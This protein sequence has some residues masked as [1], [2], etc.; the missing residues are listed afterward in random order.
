MTPAEH[1]RDEHLIAS[2]AVA[3]TQGLLV[4]DPKCSLFLQEGE[5][6]TYTL[7]CGEVI[8]GEPAL[9]EETFDD[10]RSA[11]GFF[12]D[13]REHLSRAVLG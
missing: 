9:A 3:L 11:I 8:D 5:A 1:A 13:T 4:V 2:I 12:L 7:R 10:I 6:G